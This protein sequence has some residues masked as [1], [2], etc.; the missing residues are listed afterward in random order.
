[1]QQA[2][3]KQILQ[4]LRSM[5]DDLGKKGKLEKTLRKK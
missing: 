1:M 4:M 3:H 5:Q 2:R